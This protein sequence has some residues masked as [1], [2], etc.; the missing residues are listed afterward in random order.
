MQRVRCF[1][2]NEGLDKRAE[3]FAMKHNMTLSELVRVSLEFYMTYVER[4]KARKKVVR[5]A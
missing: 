2:I 3:E 5:L 1:K 4:I